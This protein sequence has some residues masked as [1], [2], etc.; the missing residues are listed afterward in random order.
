MRVMTRGGFFHGLILG[1][2]VVLVAASP[3][4]SHMW[5]DWF[6]SIGW[7]DKTD[8]DYRIDDSIPGANGSNFEM[9]IH[10]GAAAWNAITGTGGFTYV[11]SGNGNISFQLPCNW[12]DDAAVDVWV[13]FEAISD[14]ALTT[15]C[16]VFH[17]QQQ[18]TDV[19]A[20]RVT[21]DSTPSDFTW[22]KGTGNVPAGEGSVRDASTHEL[23]HA[24]GVYRGGTTMGSSGGHWPGQ[25]SNQCALGGAESDWTMCPIGYLGE[26]FLF[27]LDAHDID[28]F[29]DYY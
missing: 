25:P 24:S 2:Y 14:P 16:E 9:R 13:F 7:D 10:D 6:D 29:Q 15:R 3:A 12:E 5:Q 21:F 23:G 27:P 1:M 20:A 19:Q 26:D 8:I 11:D 18:F 17:Q 28:T 22:Y 4:H